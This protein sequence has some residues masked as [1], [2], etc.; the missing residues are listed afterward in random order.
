MENVICPN[1]GFQFPLDKSRDFCFC[2][3]CGTK[4]EVPKYEEIQQEVQEEKPTEQPEVKNEAPKNEPKSK[5]DSTL[6]E[7]EFYYDTSFNKKEYADTENQPTYYLK[8][9]DL[10]IDLSTEFET[11]WR[12]WWEVSKPIDYKCTEFTEECRPY[13]IND[14]YFQRAVDYAPI[15]QKKELIKLADEYKERKEKFFK[16]FDEQDEKRKAEEK[17]RLEKEKAEE[18]QRLEK[19]KAEKEKAEKERLEKEKAEKEKAEKKRLEKEKAEKAEAEKK[20]AK[21]EKEKNEQEKLKAEETKQI[22]M[23]NSPLYAELASK[24][25]EKVD[26]G[27][28]VTNNANGEK[29]IVALRV[30][31][32]MMYLIGFREA[33]NN[34]ALY[35]DQSMTVKFNEQGDIVDFG[36]RPI[37]FL[38]SNSKLNVSY[39]HTGELNVN[40][41]K[42]DVNVDYVDQLMKNSKKAFIKSK[43][44]K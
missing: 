18:Q 4:I 32:K 42:L 1:C 40:D 12:I 38:P 39:I 5:V 35:C 9:Q 24:N 41:Y 28:F 29:I 16:M 10:L 25:Y 20:R 37:M 22:E 27:Y 26:G 2:L 8:A 19:E 7:V 3:K 21:E 44:F 30:V 13:T 31:S 15:E 33:S 23:M 17:E 43:I 36:N 34:N 6:E 11:D 14:M